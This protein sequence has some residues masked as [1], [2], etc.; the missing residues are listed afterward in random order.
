MSDSSEEGS[1]PTD[2]TLAEVTK[3]LII[4]PKDDQDMKDAGKN[5]AS[6]LKTITGTVDRVLSPL[7]AINN[8]FDSASKYFKKYFKKDLVKVTFGTKPENHI[9]PKI[10]VAGPAMQ[11]LAYSHEEKELKEMYLNL[12]ARA[13]D[14]ETASNA[15]PSFV[16]IIKQLN[17]EEARLLK[18]FLPHKEHEIASL[19]LIVKENGQ[20]HVVQNNIVNVRDKNDEPASNPMLSAYIDNWTRLGL[21]T[22]DYTRRKP[23]K[24]EWVK[25]RPEYK[26]VETPIIADS[27][28][29]SRVE[30]TRGVISCTKFGQ[31]FGETVGI[32]D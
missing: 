3:H 21:M 13:M 24:Y 17:A 1:S 14:S 2:G 29:Q 16:E 27:G 6:S 18:M 15:H 10:S 8:G 31:V 9:D 25:E 26:D 5:V 30:F 32:I 4:I 19:R 23:S 12:L 28:F 22:I 7:A 11:G 20:Y